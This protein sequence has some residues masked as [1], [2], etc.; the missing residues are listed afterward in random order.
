MYAGKNDAEQNLKRTF[1]T[2]EQLKPLLLD[3]KFK[4]MAL[5]HLHSVFI[6]THSLSGKRRRSLIIEGHVIVL[7]SPRGQCDR[8]ALQG[9]LRKGRKL[10]E[11]TTFRIVVVIHVRHPVIVR[12]PQVPLR[13]FDEGNLV[14]VL[15]PRVLPADHTDIGEDVE[16]S[17]RPGQGHVGTLWVADVSYVAGYV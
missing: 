10:A 12:H 9:F 1:A 8:L 15:T 17:L 3:A 11:R 6:G 13:V 2:M 7:C 16:L 5:P 4:Q 14:Q